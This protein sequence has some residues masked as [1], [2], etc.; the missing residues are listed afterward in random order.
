MNEV[1]EIVRL[2]Q[3]RGASAEML[4]SLRR[5]VEVSVVS[6]YGVVAREIKGP[7]AVGRG[8][9]VNVGNLGGRRRRRSRAADEPS[10]KPTVGP[11]DD[12]GR[13]GKFFSMAKEIIK[14]TGSAAEAITKILDLTK[15]MG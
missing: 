9:R 4:A 1:D 6:N 3:E 8:A 12:E 14:S 5:S 2:L 15:V 10:V 13:K 11:K 7:V